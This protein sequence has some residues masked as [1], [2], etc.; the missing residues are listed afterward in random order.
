MNLNSII[1]FKLLP[2]RYSGK[3]FHGQNTLKNF[4]NLQ[5]TL[6]IFSSFIYKGGYTM[7]RDI[8]LLLFLYVFDKGKYEIQGKQVVQLYLHYPCFKS[9]LVMY[10]SLLCHCLLQ[11]LKNKWGKKQSSE[12]FWQTLLRKKK[13]FNLELFLQGMQ[14]FLENISGRYILYFDINCW[15]S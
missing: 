4:V 7:T 13:N 9:W 1:F 6:K 11:I 14:V 15:A 10:N 2:R 5:Q 3:Y 12:E 8:F